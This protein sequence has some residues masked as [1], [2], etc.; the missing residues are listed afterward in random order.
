MRCISYQAQHLGVYS[1]DKIV[2]FAEYALQTHW[3]GGVM[4][5]DCLSRFSVSHFFFSGT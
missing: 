4:S 1:F 5:D 2:K 3:K